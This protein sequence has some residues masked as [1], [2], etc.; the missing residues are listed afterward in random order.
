LAT[1]IAFFGHNA[2]DAAVK[3]RI[4]SLQLTGSSVRGYTMRRDEEQACDWDNVDLGRTY[5]GAMWQRL[6]SIARAF[7]RLRGHYD[8]L[9]QADIWVARNLDMLILA[10]LTRK[11]CGAQAPLVYECLDIHPLMNRS[12]VIGSVMRAV[13]RSLIKVSERIIVS[14]PGFI[15]EYFDVHHRNQ[16]RASIVENRL[17]PGS[18]PAGRPIPGAPK[19]EAEP[20]VIG[21]YGNLKCV[22]SMALLRTLAQRLPDRIRVVL[23][24]N[25][26]LFAIPDFPTLVQDLPNLEYRGKYRYPDD[27]ERIYGELDLIW[28]GDF[29]DVRFNSRW[30]LPNRV[31]EGGYYG[32]PPVAPEGTETARWVNNRSAGWTIGDPL[33]ETLVELMRSLSHKQ[34]HQQRCKLL[35]LDRERFVQ[36][37]Q[38]ISVLLSQV[39]GRSPTSAVPVV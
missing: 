30:L 24:G 25:P 19:N 34:I 11:A 27:L 15:R 12:D 31:Y 4:G 38:E 7:P 2:Q 33:E 10:A 9:R 35:A 18:V 26:S 22:R 32:V 17:P 16:Y 28:A 3:R 20:I 8:Q 23:Y 29:W 36:P 14:S 1:R 6:A 21:W 13:E 39:L 5:D 37:E